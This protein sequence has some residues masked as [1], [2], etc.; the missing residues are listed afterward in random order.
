MTKWKESGMSNYLV[1]TVNVY[2]LD[3]KLI[4]YSGFTMKFKAEEY[5]KKLRSQHFKHIGKIDIVTKEVNY[6]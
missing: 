1:H 2:D 6:A 4:C 3:L 5:A